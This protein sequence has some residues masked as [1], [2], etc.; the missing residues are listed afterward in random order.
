MEAIEG[1]LAAQ[2]CGMLSSVPEQ[3]IVHPR[4]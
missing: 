3:K 2:P 1:L 4:G